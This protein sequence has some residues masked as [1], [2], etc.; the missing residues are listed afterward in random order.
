[1]SFD[2]PLDVPMDPPGD[3]PTTDELSGLLYS[4]A[5]P[6]V[7][8]FAK[9]GLVEGGIGP[10]Q[11]VI[12]DRAFGNADR[13]GYLP[14]TFAVSNVQITGPGL[15]SATV[16]ISGPRTSPSNTQINFVDQSGWKISRSSA[17][18]LMSKASGR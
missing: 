5:D 9:G 3:M 14:L 8:A 2:A 7:S 18:Q 16:T 13:D 1:M 11:A 15:A 6:G 17:M 10:G 12:V 4:L